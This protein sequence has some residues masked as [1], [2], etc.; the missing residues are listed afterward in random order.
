MSLFSVPVYSEETVINK[1]GNLVLLKDDHTWELLNPP[2]EDGKV[3]FTVVKAVDIVKSYD[4]DNYMKEFSHYENYAGCKYTVRVKNN[5]PHRVRV[6]HVLGLASRRSDLFRYMDGTPV[7]FGQLWIDSVLKPGESD[8]KI[9]TLVGGRLP[10]DWTGG[11]FITKSLPTDEEKALHI[12]ERG[13][14]AIGDSLYLLSMG[15][16]LIFDKDAGIFGDATKQFERGS[17]M[18][19]YKLEKNFVR[20][21]E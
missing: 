13:C 4:V 7:Q 15:G 6:D 18:G 3:V 2:A 12:K 8:S 10:G 9:V 5:T 19:V 20:D 16:E 11:E 1:D 17:S 21:V 14:E